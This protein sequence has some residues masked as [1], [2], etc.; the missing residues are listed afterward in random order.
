[1]YL[2][3]VTTERERTIALMR[4]TVP[5]VP[6]QKETCLQIKYHL[7]PPVDNKYVEKFFKKKK[8]TEEQKQLQILNT[9]TFRMCHIKIFFIVG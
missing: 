3:T 8:K 7:S 2:A 1:M 9:S 6:I 5:Q 4:L